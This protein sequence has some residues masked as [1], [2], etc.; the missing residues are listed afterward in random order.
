MNKILF[1]IGMLF[2]V[3][4]FSEKIASSLFTFVP[5]NITNIHNP[6]YTGGY[7]IVFTPLKILKN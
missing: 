3:L 2:I 4:S 6:N 5:N 7:D 1:I